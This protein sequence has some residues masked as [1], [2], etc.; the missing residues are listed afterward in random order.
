[1]AA[2][3]NMAWRPFHRSAFTLGPK[4]YL[5]S[6]GYSALKLDMPCSNTVA[7]TMLLRWTAGRW[8]GMSGAWKA[9]AATATESMVPAG[10]GAAVVLRHRAEGRNRQNAAGARCAITWGSASSYHP[11]WFLVWI[12]ST[13]STSASAVFTARL[14]KPSFLRRLPRIAARELSLQC[15]SLTTPHCGT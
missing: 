7:V 3:P 12:S 10:E 13:L 6:H 5:A 2:H 1:M 15:V 4:P 9:R 14:P 11:P 8:I